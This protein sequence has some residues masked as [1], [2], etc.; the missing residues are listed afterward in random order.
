MLAAS[1]L[2]LLLLLP[3]SPASILGILCATQRVF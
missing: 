2:L 1:L 3:S